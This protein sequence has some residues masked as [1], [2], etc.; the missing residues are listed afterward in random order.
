M[1]RCLAGEE[2]VLRNAVADLALR[3]DLD[4]LAASVIETHLR[5]ESQMSPSYPSPHNPH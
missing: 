5:P 3:G 1:F 2:N 4:P